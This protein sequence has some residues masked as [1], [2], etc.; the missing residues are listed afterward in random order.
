MRS[1]MLEHRKDAV[2]VASDTGLS[3]A[4]VTNYLKGETVHKST[5]R[6]IEMWI[7]QHSTEGLAVAK[8]AAV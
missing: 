5:E 4:T 3:P 1:V 2:N 7:K 6:L 8:T